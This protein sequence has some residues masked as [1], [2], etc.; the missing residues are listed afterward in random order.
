MKIFICEFITGGGL[1]R[2]HLQESLAKEGALMRDAILRDFAES[3]EIELILTHDARLPAPSA[4]AIAIRTEDDVWQVWKA[5]I[6]SADAVWPIA[7]ETDGLLL[8][9]TEMVTQQ[10]KVLL[11]CK[12][13]AVRIASSKY[14]TFELLKSAGIDCVETY[15]ESKLCNALHSTAWVAKLDD[16]VS[17]DGSVY[18]ANYEALEVW[19]AAGCGQA[20]IFQPYVTGVPASI[21]MLCK[22]GKA[23]LLSCNMQK[24]ELS[25]EGFAYHGSVVNGMAQYWQVFSEVAAKVANA[26]PSLQAYVGIDVIVRDGRVLVLEINPRLTTSFAGLHK[27]TG[28]NVSK[29]V[30]E[31]IYNGGF[32]APDCL[33]RH[34]VEINLEHE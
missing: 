11:A 34:V 25:E 33:A 14:A 1:Y 22:D 31:L 20:H 26:M 2:E 8:K 24:I 18:F 4:D 29:L 3:P 21:S 12:S 10:G 5:C 9:L 23:Y 28:G 30:L 16:G 13:E 15:R 27:A 6:A 7:P 32:P 17:C 19:L